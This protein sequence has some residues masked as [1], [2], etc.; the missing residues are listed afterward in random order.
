MFSMLALCLLVQIELIV[1]V[2]ISVR[3]QIRDNNRLIGFT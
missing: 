2:Y 1:Y 3:G